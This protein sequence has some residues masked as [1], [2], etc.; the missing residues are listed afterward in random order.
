MK[1]LLLN[2]K[3]FNEGRL[4]YFEKISPWKWLFDNLKAI[5]K[6]QLATISIGNSPE[7][8]LGDK[9]SVLKLLMSP[10]EDGSLPS[11]WLLDKIRFIDFGIIFPIFSWSCPSKLLLET[12]KKLRFVLWFYGKCNGPMKELP[13]RFNHCSSILFLSN[14]LGKLPFNFILDKKR[15]SKSC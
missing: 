5:N 13:W 7:K 1:W 15:A 4:K 10:I 6:V 8:L 2:S 3:T 14:Q 9:F 11:K 12:F